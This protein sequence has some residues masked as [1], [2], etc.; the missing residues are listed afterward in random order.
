MRFFFLLLLPSF[1]RYIVVKSQMTRGEA[2]ER[3][4]SHVNEDEDEDEDGEGEGKREDGGEICYD[5]LVWRQ[6]AWV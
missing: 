4:I 2:E 3:N 5:G 6:K 1:L